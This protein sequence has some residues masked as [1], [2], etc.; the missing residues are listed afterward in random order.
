M[1]EDISDTTASPPLDT[2]E[3]RLREVVSK[4][5]DLNPITYNEAISDKDS[6]N[7]P[8][9]TKVEEDIYMIQLDNFI[10][11]GQQHMI[12]K[13]HRAIYGLKQVFRSWEIRF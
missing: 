1:Q 2:L 7:W 13:L 5:H 12:F 3:P 11:K 10:A 4:E 6:R 9:A 8:S